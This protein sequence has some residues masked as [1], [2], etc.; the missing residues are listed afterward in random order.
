MKYILIAFTLIIGFTSCVEVIDLELDGRNSPLTIIEAHIVDRKD[1]SFVKLSN[2][3]DFYDPKAPPPISGANVTLSDDLGNTQ[4]FVEDSDSLGLY[5]PKDTTFAG[6]IGQT[7]HLKVEV[8][9]Q[10]FTASSVLYPTIEIDSLVV[11][12]VKDVPFREDGYYVGFYAIEPQ[13]QDNWYL[14]KTAVNGVYFS[15]FG[16]LMF[17]SDEFV[18]GSIENLELPFAF[19]LGDTVLFEQYSITKEVF[20]YYD[21]LS[22]IYFNDGGLFSP[23][24][25]NPQSNIKGGAL[26]IFITSAMVSEEIIIK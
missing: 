3:L 13:D 25:A 18:K 17:A 20:D 19:Q 5:L 23:P 14:W 6:Q 7:Y 8:K 26:G 16:D 21:Q 22:E 12:E 10:T 24:P 1:F 9:N 15:S 2:S 11:N 4:L